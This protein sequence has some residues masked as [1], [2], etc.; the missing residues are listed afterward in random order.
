M[1][2]G[3]NSEFL[4]RELSFQLIGILIEIHK[5]LGPYAREKQYSDMFEKK[6]KDAEIAY[7]RELRIAD[8][9]NI[10]DFIIDDKILIEFKVVPYLIDEHYSQ[11]KRYLHQTQL[12]LGLLINFRDKR[13]KP[14]RVLN[15]NNLK[16]TASFP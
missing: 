7:K 16:G 9:G 6:L 14:K 12:Q 10:A 3:A 8:S 1:G 4:Y 11:V 15:I 13:I 5:E 2:T